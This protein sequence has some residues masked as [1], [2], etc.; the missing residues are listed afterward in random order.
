MSG[1]KQQLLQ[2]IRGR[3]PIIYVRTTEEPRLTRLLSEISKEELGDVPLATWSHTQGLQGADQQLVLNPDPADELAQLIQNMQPG[4]YLFKDLSVFM[5]QPRLQRLI[6]DAY[7]QLNGQ[8]HTFIV[9]SSP[10]VVIPPIV[11]KN[12]YLI[13]ALL[14]DSEDLITL[15]REV[16]AEYTGK[17]IDESLYEEIAL[18]LKGLSTEEAGHTLHRVFSSGQIS[19]KRLL[20]E[21]QAGKRMIASDAD[22]LEYV[23]SIKDLSKVGGLDRLRDWISDRAS[24]FSPKA[25]DD[26]LPVPRGI[27][28]MGIS[29][30]GKSLTAKVV[31]Q[32]WRVPLFRL[33]MSGV[34]SD[35]Y[36]NPEATF[37][38]AL[39]TIESVAPAVLWIDE[40]EN[41][42]GIGEDHNSAQSH[43]LSSFL[44]WMQEKPP[45]I[46]VAATANH[47]EQ[48][49]AEMIRKGRFDQ[50]FFCD[51]PSAEE[52]AAILEIHIADAG[53]DPK[54]FRM[55]ELVKATNEFNGAELE[56][57]VVGGRITAI[58][59]ERP[60]KTDDLLEYCDT[61]V[62]LSR[63]MSEQIK[64]IRDW[65]WDRATPASSGKGTEL[66][67]SD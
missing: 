39:R 6:R 21:V 54:S 40:I 1:L 51:L 22:F 25:L 62:P 46:F 64:A 2:A 61:I 31:A 48:L 32:T 37:Q 33:N 57:T 26:G 8:R 18:S 60:L 63:T 10:E 19:R 34:F 47:I 43:I 5:E 41:G 12:V 28:V 17:D 55:A 9:I 20:E 58:A 7:F 52:R 38:K 23:P 24:L 53:D 4:I 11:K 3:H 67:L 66:D 59:E 56:Q 65:A 16:L 15:T 29:G 42:L 30:C 45:M 14:P 44:T 49:P 13:E 27:L 35:S 36:G 50:V